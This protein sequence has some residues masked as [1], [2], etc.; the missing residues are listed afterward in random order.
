MRRREFITLLG[1]AAAAWPLAARA[2]QPAMPVVGFLRSDALADAADLVTAFR[3]GLKKTVISKAKTSRL[4]SD[5]AEGQPDR[6]LALVADLVRRPVTVIVGNHN[7][8]V[9]A[10][11]ELRTVPYR[12]CDREP[13]RSGMASSPA[14]PGR[15]AISPA[16][17]NLDQSAWERND[18]T[19]LHQLRAEDD[20]NCHLVESGQRRLTE[21]GAKRRT[22]RGP[23]SGVNCIILDA[24]NDRRYRDGLCN[25]RQRGAGAL[26][27]VPAH[28]CI[29]NRERLVA[30]AARHALPAIYGDREFAMA[31]GLMSYGASIMDAYRQVGIYAGRIL[32]G[33]KPADL[34]V[35]AV[36]PNSNW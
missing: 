17:T 27:V 28:S 15:V 7:A 18:W 12:L 26:I 22:G 23:S 31:G 20:I 8:A 30:L 10:K 3:Q 6:L 14:S 29:S 13:I 32:K 5:A 36:R 4:N 2:Q 25:V 33:E 9:A 19:W 1:G 11:A 16:S 35:H 34:P 21:G 24:S